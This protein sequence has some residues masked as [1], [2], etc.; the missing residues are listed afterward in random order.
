MANYDFTPEQQKLIN[1]LLA[2]REAKRERK[3][4][5][6]LEKKVEKARKLEAVERIVKYYRATG[7]YPKY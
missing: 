1:S 4:Q 3:N 2:A 6:A 7:K 5:S